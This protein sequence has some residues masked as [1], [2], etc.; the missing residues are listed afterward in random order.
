MCL[1]R[2]QAPYWLCR[3]DEKDFIPFA[4][5]VVVCF[6][7]KVVVVIFFCLLLLFTVVVLCCRAVSSVVCQSVCV[8]EIEEEEERIEDG[9]SRLSD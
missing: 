5:F 3:I 4:L 6:A 8:R 7:G 2:V 1:F 9:R